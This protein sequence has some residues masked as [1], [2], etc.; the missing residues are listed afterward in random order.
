MPPRKRTNQSKRTPPTSSLAPAFHVPAD[1]H[2]HLRHT[3]PSITRPGVSA[4]QSVPASESTSTQQ[5][6]REEKPLAEV[7]PP[8]AR[9]SLA[10]FIYALL[11]LVLLL[12]AWHIYGMVMLLERLKDEVGWWSIVVSDSAKITR[13]EGL[14]RVG[15]RWIGGGGRGGG[16]E[17]WWLGRLA[18]RACRCT[19]YLSGAGSV[20]GEAVHS[21]GELDEHCIEDGERDRWFGGDQNTV[22][23]GYHAT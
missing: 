12:L 20:C 8:G 21:A 15:V 5:G 10:K 7:S 17:R 1:Q 13:W 19:G 4:A 11:F 22:R 14:K 2:P 9:T 3:G 18:E 16:G 6:P 23:G